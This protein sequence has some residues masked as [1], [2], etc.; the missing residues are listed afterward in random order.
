MDDVEAWTAK[1]DTADGGVV[2][3]VFAVA[4]PFPTTLP[5]HDD[6]LVVP[7]RTGTLNLLKACRRRGVRRMVLTS[8]TGAAV[9]GVRRRGNFDES[10]WTDV[11]NRSDTTPYFRSK[12][13]AERAAWDYVA[14]YVD[15][16][17]LV[18]VLPGLIL[19][20]VLEEDIGTSAA[21]VQKAMAGELPAVPKLGFGS[22]DVRSVAELHRL[23]MTHADAAG[24]R[25]IGGDEYLRFADVMEVLAKAYP[26]RKLPSRQLPDFAVRLFSYVDPTLKPVL[27]DLGAERRVTSDKARRVLGWDPMPMADSIRDTAASLLQHRIVPA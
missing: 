21:V 17:E 5:K 26:E 3:G 6:E 7:A 23:A 14:E 12:T 1:L 25:F 15:A 18:A 8:S 9:Y 10:D 4:S 2:D 22:A 13:I 24:E 27:V 19:G 11:T 16:P 20:P